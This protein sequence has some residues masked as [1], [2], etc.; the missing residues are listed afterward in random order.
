VELKK[1]RGEA[2]KLALDPLPEERA[3]PIAYMV[4]AARSG[5]A[6]E[7]I[8]ALDIN[9]DAVEILE[10][11]RQSLKTGQAVRLPLKAR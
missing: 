4:Q 2:T 10:A 11:A 1:G 9:V 8:V 7:N 5:K 6:P 3:E